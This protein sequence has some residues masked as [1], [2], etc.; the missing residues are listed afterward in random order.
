MRRKK[1][2]FAINSK[3]NKIIRLNIATKL[4]QLYIHKNHSYNANLL[5]RDTLISAK[6]HQRPIFRL[7]LSLPKKFHAN[8]AIGVQWTPDFKR[9]FGRKHLT[10]INKLTVKTVK[11]NNLNTKTN[12]KR[13]KKQ[14][15]N[16]VFRPYHIYSVALPVKD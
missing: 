4:Q 11:T 8:C 3:A 13:Y 2:S 14:N 16:A 10:Q 9:A 15:K 1:R 5:I 7:T 12:N 6:F